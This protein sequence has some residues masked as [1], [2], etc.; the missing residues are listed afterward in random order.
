L[1]KKKHK[2]LKKI[3]LEVRLSLYVVLWSLRI[4]THHIHS[5]CTEMKRVYPINFLIIFCKLINVNCLII[6]TKFLS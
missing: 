4:Y 5:L 6:I 3:K 2:A 1:R